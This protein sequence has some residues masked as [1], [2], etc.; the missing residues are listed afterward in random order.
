MTSVEHP[1]IVPGSVEERRYQTA[2]VQGCLRNNTLVILP[3][4]LE[5][6]F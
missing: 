1:R 4:G 5:N 2:M 3:T 6:R